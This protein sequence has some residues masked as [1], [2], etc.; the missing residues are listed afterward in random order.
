MAKATSIVLDLFKPFKT[1]TINEASR[2]NDATNYSQDMILATY[3]ITTSNLKAIRNKASLGHKVHLVLR[4]I[5]EERKSNDAVGRRARPP[6]CGRRMTSLPI[7]QLY[8]LA[9]IF[10]LCPNR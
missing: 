7:P 8:V 10:R 6:S 3:A 4:G 5:A 9:S 2:K 1:I